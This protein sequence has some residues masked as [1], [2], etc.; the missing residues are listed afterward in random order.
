MEDGQGGSSGQSAV[1]LAMVAYARGLNL[2]YTTI[3]LP[4]AR[5]APRM[6]SFRRKCVMKTNAMLNLVHYTY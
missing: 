4:K 2:A 5:T 3:L 6:T 1:R